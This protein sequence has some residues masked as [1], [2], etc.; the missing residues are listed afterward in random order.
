MCLK[1]SSNASSFVLLLVYRTGPL[2][3]AFFDELSDVLDFLAT[4]S[5]PLI[6]AGDLNIHVERSQDLHSR[7]L[8]DT[9]AS[10][11]LTCRV[12][13]PIHN[14]GGTLDVVFTQNDLPVQVSGSLTGISDHSLLTWSLPVL[15]PQPFYITTTSRSW[16]Q[17]DLD[18]LRLCLADSAL[19]QPN[20]W[21]SLDV[22][23]LT[24]LWELNHSA[25]LDSL[26]PLRTVTLRRR[27]CEHRQ[28]LGQERV[29]REAIGR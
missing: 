8:L 19:C 17:L 13:F 14:L 7:L 15:T 9:C 23:E 4:C 10:H 11:G 16:Q 2:T 5:A 28:R 27:P 21:P 3:T 26:V 6:V 25:I 29:I 20:V 18:N 1:F 24:S 22:D 12:N